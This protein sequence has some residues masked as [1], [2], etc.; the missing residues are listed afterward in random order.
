M[1]T[2]ERLDKLL[3]IR[4]ESPKNARPLGIAGWHR[5]VDLHR[6]AALAA[7]SVSTPWPS[8][9]FRMIFR[10]GNNHAGLQTRERSVFDALHVI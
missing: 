10:C 4:Y 3:A 5:I 8:P 7:H 2:G 1:L 6:C 9:H